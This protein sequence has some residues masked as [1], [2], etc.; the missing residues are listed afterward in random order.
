MAYPM[1]DAKPRPL[2]VDFDRRAR[3]GFRS[4][5]RPDKGRN[6]S[7]RARV[8]TGIAVRTPLCNLCGQS[9]ASRIRV[10][11]ASEV[12]SRSQ[13]PASVVIIVQDV[14]DNPEA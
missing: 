14:N 8:T 9:G 3:S 13:K 12:P 1:G 6:L 5:N 11:D 2:R 10:F 4:P 7:Y